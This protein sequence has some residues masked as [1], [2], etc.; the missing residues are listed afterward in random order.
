LEIAPGKLLCTISAK[1]T[2]AA[3]S[4][5]VSPTTIFNLLVDDT[6]DAYDDAYDDD[7]YDDDLADGATK[8][9]AD[10]AGVK[11]IAILA[12]ENFMICA[13]LCCVD[14]ICEY[15]NIYIFMLEMVLCCVVYIVR[16]EI[17]R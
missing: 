13:V 7:A 1:W 9:L 6:Y 12:E 2:R 10:D 5:A 14:A 11:R 8:A 17:E 4:S 16:R 15:N 3:N